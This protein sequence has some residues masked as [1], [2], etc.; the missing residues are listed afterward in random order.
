M[1]EAGR[2]VFCAIHPRVATKICNAVPASRTMLMRDHATVR[3]RSVTC[4]YS[5]IHSG[6]VADYAFTVGRGRTRRYLRQGPPPRRRRVLRQLARLVLL[7]ELVGRDS[8]RRRLRRRV[9]RTSNRVVWAI[10]RGD[11]LGAAYHARGRWIARSHT[12]QGESRCRVAVTGERRYGK[13][14]H[15]RVSAPTVWNSST[16][17]WAR[18]R[19]WV[20]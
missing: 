12:E 10:G 14:R 19:L 3:Y 17:A 13:P 6:G 7:P 1:G 5:V 15:R 9:A 18:C 11:S 20:Q 2:L 16:P 4:G 8:I